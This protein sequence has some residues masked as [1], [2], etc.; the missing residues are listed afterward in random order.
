ME[1]ALA[2]SRYG[3]SWTKSHPAWGGDL[4]R[5]LA[6]DE[7]AHRLSLGCGDFTCA[8][9]CPQ[10]AVSPEFSGSV[11]GV[12]KHSHS[13]AVGADESSMQSISAFAHSMG[14]LPGRQGCRMAR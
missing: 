1:C 14:S 3:T 12:C 7:H 2:L 11:L 6:L 8:R 5:C 4:C 13:G 10:R 9:S